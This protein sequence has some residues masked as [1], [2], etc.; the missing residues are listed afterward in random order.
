MFSTPAAQRAAV[1]GGML[2]VFAL[3]LAL[4]W[5]VSGA[6]VGDPLAPARPGPG[7]A[8][9]TVIDS[10]AKPLPAAEI[11]WAKVGG[12]EV[13]LPERLTETETDTGPEAGAA[14][15]GVPHRVWT[16][17]RDPALRLTVLVDTAERPTAP[18]VVAEPWL[19]ALWSE[20]LQDPARIAQTPPGAARRA[21]EIV[22]IPAPQRGQRRGEID[23]LAAASP[24]GRRF[25]I[26][27]LRDRTPDTAS[28]EPRVGRGLSLLR[29]IYQNAR[30]E[31]KP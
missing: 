5:L 23:L 27:H 6:P 20:Q 8:R 21:F 12:V 14:L 4:A 18:R 19:R 26:V 31:D 3:S 10:P 28:I 11:V 1:G 29:T 17:P 24:D 9:P 7:Q 13:P 25:L 22:L 2:A 30:F 15:S 16:D